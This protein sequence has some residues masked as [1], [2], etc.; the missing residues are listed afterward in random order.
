MLKTGRGRLIIS[1]G[2]MMTAA[3]AYT[4]VVWRRAQIAAAAAEQRRREEEAAAAAAVAAAQRRREEEAAPCNL[5]KVLLSGEGGAAADT[6]ALRHLA[7]Q[8]TDDSASVRGVFIEAGV[9]TAIAAVLRR[10]SGTPTPPLVLKGAAYV[11]CQ[12]CEKLKVDS[13]VDLDDI[14]FSDVFATIVAAQAQEAKRIAIIQSCIKAGA[15]AALVDALHRLP[16]SDCCCR[17][18]DALT[19]IASASP[20]FA[21][22][23]CEVGAPRATVAALVGHARSPDVCSKA[24]LALEAAAKGRGGAAAAA[25]HL[26]AAVTAR[27]SDADASAALARAILNFA[28][29]H[30]EVLSQAGA[31]PALA[32]A[33]RMH[34]SSAQGAELRTALH[35]LGLDKEGKPRGCATQ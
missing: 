14:R 24:D 35:T 11:L 26:V 22:S 12:L 10:H 18:L 31:W 30:K 32:A 34:A 4:Y 6:E 19:C 2:A 9:P 29:E 17:L 27:S 16:D 8:L 7:N 28:K 21:S 3:A 13:Q 15:V 23:C 1:L 25:Q 33:A 20:E 5:V